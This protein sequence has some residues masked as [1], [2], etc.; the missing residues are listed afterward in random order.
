[1]SADRAKTKRALSEDAKKARAAQILVNIKCK[2]VKDVL[3]KLSD[4]YG[5]D[6]ALKLVERSAMEPSNVAVAVGEKG[7]S[8]VSAV[9]YLANNPLPDEAVAKIV[10]V[11]PENVR[12]GREE[13]KE[14]L[15]IPEIVV[16]TQKQNKEKENR[17]NEMVDSRQEQPHK[18]QAVV[19]QNRME[20]RIAKLDAKKQAADEKRNIL[21]EKKLSSLGFNGEEVMKKLTEKYGDLAEDI[22]NRSLTHPTI[23][24]SQ[25]GE[26]PTSSK[27]TIEHYA[28][29]EVAPEKLAKALGKDLKTIEAAIPQKAPVQQEPQE[30]D[31]NTQFNQGQGPLIMADKPKED[32]KYV[33]WG[34]AKDVEIGQMK[35]EDYGRYVKPEDRPLSD[36]KTLRKEAYKDFIAGEGKHNKMYLDYR[37]NPT[38][39]V[40]HLIMPV[41]ELGNAEVT[42]RYKKAYQALPM[43]DK[44]GQP[45]SAEA[46]GAQFD[47]LIAAMKNKSFQTKAIGGGGEII[48]NPEMGKLSDA[49]VEQAFNQDFDYWYKQTKNEIP[50]IDHCPKSLQLATIHTSFAGR[51]GAIKEAEDP[52]SLIE[53][54]SRTRDRRGTSQG[55]RQTIKAANDSIKE[56]RRNYEMDMKVKMRTAQLEQSRSGLEIP[57]KSIKDIE[58]LAFLQKIKES[59]TT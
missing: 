38:I 12:A 59:R 34:A 48:L 39:G 44:N 13:T 8:S 57:S 42:E 7:F 50:Y 33:Q 58:K 43:Q 46:K 52:M 31:K 1:M 9:N 45:L 4:E 22:V 20:E 5:A 49:G 53:A 6:I 54:V 11:P 19:N 21:A 3:D 36:Y 26:S 47:Q 24:M 14:I 28:S 10:R 29:S 32:N 18:E 35:L 16:V 15:N 23:M 41:K 30:I 55:E 27:K 51:L 56:A 17:F 2:D 40:G 37:G 25:I